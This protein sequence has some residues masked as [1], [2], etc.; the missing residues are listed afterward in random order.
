MRIL[1]CNIAYMKYYKGIIKNLDGPR[2]GGGY[3]QR[4][5][6]AYEKYNFLSQA[7]DMG[8]RC[9][10][11]F[12]TKSTNGKNANQLHIEK[13][14]N[15]SK[16]CEKATNV[17]VIWCAKFCHNRSVIVGWYKNANVYRNY[18][19]TDIV[20]ADGSLYSQAYNIEAAAEDCVLLS[21]SERNVNIWTAP[22]KKQNLSYG[23]GQSN[24]WFAAEESAI[25]YVEKLEKNIENFQSENW[26]RKYPQIKN[27][28]FIIKI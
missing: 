1:F 9:Y 23:F 16:E 26:L 15:I 10:G 24:V 25:S 7:S 19:H 20:L 2:N 14:N 22:R 11:F 5:G 4:T 8:E 6:D 13:I 17:L 27:E 18:E 21:E 3:V 12:E 28:Q